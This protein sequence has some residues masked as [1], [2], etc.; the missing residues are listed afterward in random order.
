VQTNLKDQKN[1][2]ANTLAT[3]SQYGPNT[4]IKFLI[5]NTANVDCNKNNAPFYNGSSN[6]DRL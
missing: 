1:T 4:C 6:R 2:S 5:K 3:I